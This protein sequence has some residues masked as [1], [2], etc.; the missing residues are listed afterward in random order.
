[1]DSKKYKSL[2]SGANAFSR[3]DLEET[4]LALKEQ[5]STLVSELENILS[6]KPIEKPPMYEGGLICDYF[7]VSISQESAEE[8]MENIGFMETDSVGVDG[9]I[10]PKASK[11]ASLLDH[12][13]RYLGD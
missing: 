2:C 11:Y 4:L 6:A 10:T 5:N 13:Y 12:W 7:I 1:M 8:I 9:S 3:K